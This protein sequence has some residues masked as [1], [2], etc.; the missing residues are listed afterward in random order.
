[1][2]KTLGIF[3][4]KKSTYNQLILKALATGSKKTWQIAEYIYLNRGSIPVTK[5]NKNEVKK[6]NKVICWEN[7]RLNELKKKEYIGRENI[8]WNLTTKGNAVSL[9]LFADISEIMPF[10]EGINILELK[11][12]MSQIFTQLFDDI[13]PRRARK[14]FLKIFDKPHFSELFIQRIKGYAAKLIQDGVNL[15]DMSDKEFESLQ[16]NHIAHI[17]LDMT[18]TYRQ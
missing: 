2:S 13:V 9:T 5:L 10:I 18:K 3:T 17:F 7:G 15:D 16:S 12:M 11:E 1:M 8:L 14:N 4:G 6:I